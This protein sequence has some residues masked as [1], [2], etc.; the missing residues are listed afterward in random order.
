MPADGLAVGDQRRDR[1]AEGP[2]ELAVGAGLAFVDLRA[3]GMEREHRGFA[4]GGDGF[5]KGRLG[6]GGARRKQKEE[7]AVLSDGIAMPPRRSGTVL[8]V[9]ARSDS[10]EAIHSTAGG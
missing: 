2:G 8:T 1:L 6:G 3:L 4:G 7:G 5:G 10:D 9:V